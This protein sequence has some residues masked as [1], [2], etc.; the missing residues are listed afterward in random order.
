MDNLPNPSIY[1]G[2]LSEY[3]SSFTK[4]INKYTGT[5]PH[6]ITELEKSLDSTTL[7]INSDIMKI[8]AEIASLD[9]KIIEEKQKNKRLDLE[10]SGKQSTI[11][12]AKHMN[13][14]TNVLLY[15]QYLINSSNIIGIILL[16]IVLYKVKSYS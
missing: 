2:I 9:K 16:I 7:D 14:D 1:E 13:V 3:N 11:A 5:D 4:L 8:D 6:Q 15:T 12:G 10:L